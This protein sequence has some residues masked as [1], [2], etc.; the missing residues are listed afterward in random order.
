MTDDS[1]VDRLGIIE[2]QPLPERAQAYQSLHDELSRTL[3][4]AP[5][6]DE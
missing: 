2:A 1:L 3:E 4:R 6:T 5:E